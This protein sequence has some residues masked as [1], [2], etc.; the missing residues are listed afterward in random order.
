MRRAWLVI[1]WFDPSIGQ[2]RSLGKTHPS[3]IF[4]EKDSYELGEC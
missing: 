2:G 4:I 1:D 3:D